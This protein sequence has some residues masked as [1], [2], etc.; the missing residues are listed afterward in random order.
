MVVL[1]H[2]RIYSELENQPELQTDLYIVKAYCF[3]SRQDTF[4]KTKYY[5]KNRYVNANYQRKRNHLLKF[6]WLAN[7]LIFLILI[8]FE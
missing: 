2:T 3:E 8:F 4:L 6:D 7:I 5:E 1:I